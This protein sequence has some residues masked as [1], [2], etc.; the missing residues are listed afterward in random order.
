[1]SNVKS[2]VELAQLGQSLALAKQNLELVKKKK[3]KSKD[4]LKVGVENIVGIKL[5]AETGKVISGL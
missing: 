5:I 4:F 2:V 3:K 1:M